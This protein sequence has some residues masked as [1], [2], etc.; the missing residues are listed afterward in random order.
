V[1]YDRFLNV[2][3]G[4][5]IYYLHV[6]NGVNMNLEDN[7]NP[8][9][10]EEKIPLI[11]FIHGTDETCFDSEFI[12]QPEFK[13]QCWLEL[14]DHKKAVTL[15]AQARGLWAN[16]TSSWRPPDD[17]L[18]SLWLPKCTDPNEYDHIYL[19]KCVDDVL[20]I[21]PQI[22]TNT[23]YVIGFSNGGFMACDIALSELFLEAHLM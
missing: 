22:D 1:N 14:S 21:I 6:P 12:Y 2:V 13:T 23:I 8:T 7:V 18:K 10:N 17:S 20:K 19:E 15:F 5:R 4:N 11:V 3:D 9:I 16:Y